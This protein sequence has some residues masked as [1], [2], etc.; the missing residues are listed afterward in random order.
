MVKWS[1]VGEVVP[2]DTL[3]INK[4]I[5][6]EFNSPFEEFSLLMELREG[7]SGPPRHPHPHAEA[8]GHLRA[9][10]NGCSSGRP[11]RSEDKIRAKLARHPGVELDILRQYVVLYGWIKGLDA[12]ETAEQ[13]GLE[14]RERRRNFWRA[15]PA[16]SRT[17]W[18]RKAT[19]SWT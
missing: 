8:A 16:W 18:S 19:G 10:A 3:T 12:V 11:G 6:A 7:E 1:R 4:F 13:F 5:H 15:R 9:A 14:G 17:S 2:L